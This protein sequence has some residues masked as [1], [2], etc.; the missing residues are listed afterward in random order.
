MQ[1]GSGAPN[2]A[3][4]AP[5]NEGEGA[6][7]SAKASSPDPPDGGTDKTLEGVVQVSDAAQSARQPDSMHVRWYWTVMSCS[8]CGPAPHWKILQ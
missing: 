6:A 7:A 2:G 5:D 3:D 4:E 8:H 1:E